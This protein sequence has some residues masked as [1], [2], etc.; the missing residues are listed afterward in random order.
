MPRDI[1]PSLTA[2]ARPEG[3]HEASSPGLSSERVRVDAGPVSVLRAQAVSAVGP[4]RS[5]RMKLVYVAGGST[6]ITYDAG[7]LP[8][9]Q[10]EIAFLPAERTYAGTP[11]AFVET[12][13]VYIDP[14]FAL[15]QLRWLQSTA[16]FL[17]ELFSAPEP[18][19]LTVIPN[20]RAQLHRRLHELTRLETIS[21][22]AELQQMAGLARVLSLIHPGGGMPVVMPDPRHPEVEE[23]IK[24]LEGD[25]E[26]PW[27]VQT[28][29]DMVAL[30]PSQLT[31]LFTRY[32]GTSPA[33]YLREA[34]ARRMHKLL[35]DGVVNVSEAARLVGWNDLSHASRAYQTVFGQTPSTVQAQRTTDSGALED[36]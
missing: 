35:V 2:G 15:D 14:Q 31:R 13:A 19:R 18:R 22:T 20:R 6:K 17:E 12:I 23:A 36:W 24:V 8:M 28:L 16:P 5:S 33:R 32:A 1:G 11:P 27:T 34:R 21:P 25:L 4:T 26:C 9:L 3:P 29:A 10:G 30:S 7:T